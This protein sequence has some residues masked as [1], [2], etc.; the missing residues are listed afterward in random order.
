MI[1]RSEKH[2]K[3]IQKP[4]NMEQKDDFIGKR[5]NDAKK[6]FGMAK[7]DALALMLVLSIVV[8]AVFIAMYI[9]AKDEVLAVSNDLNRQIQDEIRRQVPAA[10]NK[11]VTTQ[12]KPIADSVSTTQEKIE[13]VIKEIVK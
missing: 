7:E 4:H 8:N 12:V 6:L 3:N 2:S 13:N 10:V 9:N 5:V 1:F 11:E